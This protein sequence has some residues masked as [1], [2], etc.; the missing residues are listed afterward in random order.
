MKKYI[1]TDKDVESINVAVEEL[2]ALIK[3]DG[4][5][6]DRTVLKAFYLIAT[7]IPVEFK[8]ELTTTDEE[9]QE[10]YGV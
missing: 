4:S 3:A 2:R 7:I 10:Q 5:Q 9:Y 8:T 1:I 6:I